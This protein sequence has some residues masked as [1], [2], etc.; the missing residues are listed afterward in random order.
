MA[1]R[2]LEGD[3]PHVASA[4]KRLKW[5]ADRHDRLSS[6]SNEVLLRVLSFLSIG[7]LNKCQRYGLDSTSDLVG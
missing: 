1:K 5:E 7:E 3:E 6:L 2:A 4:A